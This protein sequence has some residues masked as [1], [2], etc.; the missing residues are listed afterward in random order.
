MDSFLP[1]S[2]F[3]FEIH[4]NSPSRQIIR[5]LFYGMDFYGKHQLSTSSH[6]SSQ[7]ASFEEKVLE[8]HIYS[9]GRKA[10]WLGLCQL[11]IRQKLIGKEISM[12]G[13]WNIVPGAHKYSTVLSEMT[14]L[15]PDCGLRFTV[16]FINFSAWWIMNVSFTSLIAKP[17]LPQ[18]LTRMLYPI[19]TI[20]Q[21]N[22]I[23]HS[24][25]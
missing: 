10:L 2:R 25:W 6:L 22:C 3:Y 9:R 4:Q 11:F 13:I 20:C 21:Y 8:S 12:T 14:Y 24:K 5:H 18:P 16:Q 17:W 19:I 15:S 23:K 1:K 7:N